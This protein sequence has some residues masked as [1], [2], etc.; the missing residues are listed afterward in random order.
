MELTRRP[1]ETA[2][3]A[4]A[5]ELL[6]AGPL[7]PVP[8]VERIC[9]MP[10]APRMVAEH[11]AVALLAGHPNFARDA[12][13]RWMLRC[14]APRWPASPGEQQ[15]AAPGPPAFTAAASA[16]TPTT[17]TTAASP[18]PPALG[19]PGLAPPTPATRRMLCSVSWVVV[20]VE[21][22][23]GRP[24]GED[25]IT[26]VAAVVVRDGGIAERFETLV[27]PQRPIP[28]FI[29]R[30]TNISWQMVRDKPV[31]RDVC[32]QLLRVLQ[33][34]VFVAHNARFDWAF[35]CAEV[36]RATGERLEGEQ[37]CTVRLARKLLPQ[38]RRRSLDWVA[39]HYGIA[40]D[41]RHR[42]GGDADATARVL[43]CLLRDAESRGI[44]CWDG[45]SRLTTGGTGRGRRR[46][47]SALPQPVRE[48]TTA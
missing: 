7:D 16:A 46:R 20:D 23:G 3:I 6:R 39:N 24:W 41:G 30:L 28:P 43:Q 26:E 8:L 22:T 19:A 34:N 18:L 29:S 9:S 10:G 2:L 4:R 15:P 12:L 48:D 32:E 45:L 47:A 35:I 11:M 37:L 21:T 42:A 14:E 25:R 38:L 1:A 40:I 33:G 17:P 27:N 36:E 5:A 44:E 31:F 13:G